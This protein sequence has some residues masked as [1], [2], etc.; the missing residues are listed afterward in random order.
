MDWNSEIE[1]EEMLT[2]EPQALTSAEQEL[3]VA[4]N[5]DRLYKRAAAA[6]TFFLIAAAALMVSFK[7]H[8]DFFDAS[9]RFGLLMESVNAQEE[10]KAY[11]KI[12]VKVVFDDKEESRLVIPLDALADSANITIHEEFTKKKLTITLKEASEQIA[13]GIRMTGDSRIMDA[14]GIYRQ[15]L[16]V[17][18]EVYCKETY[19]YVT[20]NTGTA[21]T[22]N[23]SPLRD[24]Y[25]AVAVVYIPYEDRSRLELP[26]WHQ[27]LADFVS[28]NRI[29]LFM[30]SDM[31]EAYTQQEVSAFAE[32]VNADIVLGLDVSVD[33]AAQQTT[34]EAFCNTTYFMPDFNSAQLSVIFAETLVSKVQIDF[35]GFAEAQAD[36]PLIY[37]AT[38]PAAMLKISQSQKDADSVETVYKLNERLAAVIRDT[39]GSVYGKSVQ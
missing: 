10:N 21:L 26:E 9:S 18:V 35:L 34:A 12:N 29:R 24:N 28:D 25:D 30:A 38:C 32:S 2:E 19:S 39:L 37:D 22:I 23:F 13:D 6:A 27:S 1:Q 17:V 8:E 5:R 4:Q 31:Q 20:Q 33:A 14:V 7:L 11:P 16:D 36:M 15:H 3:I